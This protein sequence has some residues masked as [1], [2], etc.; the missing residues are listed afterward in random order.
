MR[1]SAYNFVYRGNDNAIIFNS[2][3]GNCIVVG[4][5]LLDNFLSYDVSDVEKKQFKDMGFYVDDGFDE[6][7]SIQERCKDKTLT[8]NI[9]K[10]RILTTTGCNA[11][12]FYC[13]EKGLK[14]VSMSIDTAIDTAKFILAHTKKDDIVSVEWFGGEPLLNIP[15]IDMI[16]EY[17]LSRLPINTQYR[18]GIIT[19]GSMINEE[20]I[21]KMV[22][23]WGVQRVQIT[24]DG[25]EA[26]Y[27]D[28]KQLGKGSFEHAIDIIKKL[29]DKKIEVNIRINYDSSNIGDVE[30]LAKYF[31]TFSHKN[32]INVYAAKIFSSKTKRGYFDLE[33]ETIMVDEILHKY[34]LKQKN[35]ILPKVFK[36]TCMAT[37]P[38][39]FTIDPRGRVFKCDRRLLDKNTLAT[40]RNYDDSI[41][42]HHDWIHLDVAEKCKTCKL[43]PLCWG[44][45]I[46]DRINN[47][48]PCYLTEAIVINRLKIALDDYNNQL[49]IS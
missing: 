18:A 25:V 37:Y 5:A 15:A 42:E 22:E 33:K 26:K 8:S 19:N 13:Y 10:Y 38:G 2:C 17:V 1:L 43:Y 27:D 48:Y 6:F 3:T 23:N 46:Y 36:T 44:G 39:F 45:C 40:V 31:S 28:V 16:S 9:N 32:G 4:L 29:V 49:C 30:E 34:G 47:I 20:L 41:L 35:D 12:C 14:T 7:H 11:R 24:I 21:G